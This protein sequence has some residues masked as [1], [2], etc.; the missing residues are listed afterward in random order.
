LSLRAA[1]KAATVVAT[2]VV[3]GPPSAEAEPALVPIARVGPWSGVSEL[4]GY[5][6]RLWFVNSVKFVNHNSADLYSYDP[7]SGEARYER[8]L[9]SQD[10]GEAAVAEGLIFWPFED[11]RFSVGRGEY[12]VSNGRDWRWH[13]LPEGTVFHV[14]AMTYW[15][16][17][18]IA[19]T[20]AW[21]AGLQRSDDLGATWRIIYDHPTEQGYVSRIT[22]LG[23]LKDTVFAGLTAWAQDGIK[24]LRLRGDTV[25]P[26]TGWPEGRSTRALTAW[27]GWLYGIN[28]DDSASALWR[29][30]GEAVER[31]TALDGLQVRAL[32]DG[33]EA[34]WA[35]TVGE[36]NG[37]LWRSADGHTWARQQIFTADEPLDVIVYA[38]RVYVGALGADGRGTLWGPP[39]PAPVGSPLVPT[40]LPPLPT[41]RDRDRVD[42]LLK[43][44]DQALADPASYK[45]GGA[46]G[47]ALRPLTASG[48]PE[49]GDEL[50]KRL[51]GPF[52][53]GE[54][55]LF[56]GNV[57]VTMT[58]LGRWAL[59]RAMAMSGGGRVPRDLLTAPFSIRPN[60]AEKYL[61]IAPAAA[62]AAGLLG[63]R[64]RGTL[65]ALIRRLGREGEPDWLVGDV[66]GALSAL[67]G[68]RFG[69]DFAAWRAWIVSSATS[70]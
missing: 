56:G 19:A 48:L 40:P 23:V 15:R 37:T 5:G 27:R 32:A 60:R 29:T 13:G 38:G 34:L 44:L 31:V 8:H 35:I 11:A 43:A 7:N 14:H 45:R 57:K 12:M 36:G 1:F 68:Q 25:S 33:P 3:T 62:F 22:S 42:E 69:Y 63:Q 51:G 61:E 54:V 4:V 41:E 52:P 50:A 66:V 24:L 67:T 18:L 65:T 30:D 64:D 17:A 20:S 58:T 6:D 47:K 21:R 55:A 10:A 9:F 49:V 16:G 46:L 26:V 70:K 39:A 28:T 59:M 53:Q 2:L